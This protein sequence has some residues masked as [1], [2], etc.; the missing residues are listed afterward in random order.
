MSSRCS[1][2]PACSTS[3]ALAAAV[4]DHVRVDVHAARLDAG[5]SQKPEELAPAAADVEHRAGVSKVV[6]V[7]PLPVA[8]A[9]RRPAH[10]TLVGEVVGHGDGTGH[11]RWRRGGGGRLS[12]RRPLATLE[13]GEPLVDLDHALETRAER[14]ELGLLP[15]C[16]LP[17]GVEELER[18]G[19][20]PALV[21]RERLD[22]PA[23]RLAQDALERRERE[24]AQAPVRPGS[25][26]KRPLGADGPELLG[27]TPAALVPVRALLAAQVVVPA[28]HL[29]AQAREDR[30]ELCLLGSQAVLRHFAIVGTGWCHLR[31]VGLGFPFSKPVF[32]NR[33]TLREDGVL[34]G[35]LRDHRRVVQQARA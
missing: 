8:N 33:E 13:P 22:V 9:L 25:A 14:L 23:H 12:G 27:L 32:E 19:V 18:G 21:D 5:L 10:P 34:L 26:Q 24:P 7:R 20:E 30:L 6:H 17:N 16:P 29:I 4:G 11:A 28:I 3:Q 35:E 15:V 2:A 31:S 1:I